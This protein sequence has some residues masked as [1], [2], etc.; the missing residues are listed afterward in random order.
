[1]VNETF[2]SISLPLLA[3]SVENVMVVDENQT[4]LDYELD[5]VNLTVFSLGVQSVQVEYDTV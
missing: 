4:V 5:G 2:Q 3:A 1:M